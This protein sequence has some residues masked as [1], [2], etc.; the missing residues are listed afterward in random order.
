MAKGVTSGYAPLG[1]VGMR[2]NIAKY[3]ADQKLWCGL[4]GYAPPISCAAAVANIQVYRQDQLIEN[5][6]KQETPLRRW[7]TDQHHYPW[8]G[9]A[10]LQTKDSDVDL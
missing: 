5:A 3:F 4:T 10:H 2:P 8:F 7:L 1:V 9:D 6:K